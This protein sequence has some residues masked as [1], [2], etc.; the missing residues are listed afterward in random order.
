[1]HDAAAP[2]G[3]QPGHHW[4]ISKE[5]AIADFVKH[6]P[7]KVVTIYLLGLIGRRRPP[8]GGTLMRMSPKALKELLYSDLVALDDAGLVNML[9]TVWPG[10]CSAEEAADCSDLFV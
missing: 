8:N 2:E 1:M 3:E 9:K 5:G 7:S 4:R 10:M 6:S